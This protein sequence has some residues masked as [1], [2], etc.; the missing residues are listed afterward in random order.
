M[1]RPSWAGRRDTAPP[2]GHTLPPVTAT[3]ISALLLILVGAAARRFG[4]LKPENGR[5][6][7]DVVLYLA[8][9]ALVIDILID[10]TL[11]AELLL[12][13][14][15]C[16]LIHLALLG[17]CFLVARVG[18]RDD[19]TT[20]AI[21]VAGAVGNTG[22]FGL[23]L[24]AASGGG[25]SL[26]AAVM[27]DTLGTGIITWT[28]TVLVAS[29]FGGEGASRKELVRGVGR[30]LALPPMWALGA[31]LLLNL[32]HADPPDWIDRPFEIL[33]AATLPLVMIYAGLVMEPRGIRK[34]WGEVTVTSVIRLVVAALVGFAIGTGLGLGGPVLDTVVI[35]AA[36]PTAMMS[37]VIGSM[38][39]LRADVLAGAVLV[40]TLLA[41]I[42]LP[43]LRGLLT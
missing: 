39:G 14:V 34:A 26:P 2:K 1:G 24:I 23:P 36:M 13:P 10:A 35:M 42:T 7:V 15:A 32:L 6:L 29:M 20:G 9:P 8:L 11:S 27:Y 3:A 40:T 16:I 43:S 28:S 22:F 18:R 17:I 21:M 31:G 5:V 25:L 37:L 30:A 4:V 19:R 38:H 41:T 12:V 33:G